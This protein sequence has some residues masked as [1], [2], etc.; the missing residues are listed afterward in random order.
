M[1]NKYIISI[2]LIL[3][4]SLWWGYY[5]LWANDD[6]T[7]YNYT[8]STSCSINWKTFSEA[9]NMS[10]VSCTDWNNWIS[11]C[12]W[13]VGTTTYTRWSSYRCTNPNA[14]SRSSYSIVWQAC[15]V[16]YIDNKSPTAEWGI[17]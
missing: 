4:F 11:D 2:V 10:W 7:C 5:Y 12:S 16:R 9:K 1:K 6:W 8:S 17:E 13:N 15:T 3:L 14:E